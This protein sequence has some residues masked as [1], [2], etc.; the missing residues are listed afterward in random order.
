MA[1]A[2]T[3][4]IYRIISDS[5]PEV[6]PYI[7]STIRTLKDRW[8]QHKSPTNQTVSKHLMEFEDVRM[9]LLEEI[10]CES[11]RTLH[12][13]EQWYID[14]NECCNKINAFGCDWK[15]HKSYY[16]ANKEAQLEYNKAY[17]KANKEVI[18]QQ[19][20]AY[21]ET[22]KEAIKEYKKAYRKANREHENELRRIRRANRLK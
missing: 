10:V 8:Y 3:G 7:G 16:E 14:N 21:V 12:Q 20:K 9:E 6:L 1:E 15:E 19:K 2:I 5:H 13:R 22:H 17:R 11:L 18:K 4:R